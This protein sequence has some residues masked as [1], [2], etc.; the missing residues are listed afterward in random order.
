[1]TKQAST[2]LTVTS[3][4]LIACIYLLVQNFIRIPKPFYVVI[5]KEE[6]LQ[7]PKSSS[8]G[9]QHGDCNRR[10]LLIV[11]FSGAGLSSART[12]QRN[13]CGPMYKSHAV[14]RLFAVGMP[15]FDSRSESEH[16]Q[17]QIATE[18][19]INV[20]EALLEEHKTFGD[21]MITP[22]RDQYRDLTEKMMSMLR[23]GVGQDV[24][25]IFK[26]DDEYCLNI[27]LAREMICDHETNHENKELYVGWH[28]FHGMEYPSLMRGPHNET[29]PFM[30]GWVIGLSR[31]LTKTIVERD[32]HFNILKAS[33]GTSSDDANLGKMVQRAILKHNISVH[34][35]VDAGLVS[36]ISDMPQTM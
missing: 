23:Y 29:A 16:V 12:S 13:L 5:G 26:V 22:N 24:D 2:S 31:N 33:Y 6:E 36:K 32:W 10:K 9:R 21:V 15:S 4:V 7:Q 34:F 3:T 11:T 1:M 20:S 35:S 30:S 19:E 14:P 18:Q 28:M 8:F 25:Y 17:G 27:T